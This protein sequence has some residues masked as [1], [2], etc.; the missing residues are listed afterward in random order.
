MTQPASHPLRRPTV[1]TFSS[2]RLWRPWGPGFWEVLGSLPGA[3]RGQRRHDQDRADRLRRA[4]HGAAS[5][6][7]STNGNVKLVAMGDA[8]AW[9]LARQ[10]SAS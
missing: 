2:L 9:Q 6:A 3:F 8:F 7:L 4:R 5:Q 1:A 10:P